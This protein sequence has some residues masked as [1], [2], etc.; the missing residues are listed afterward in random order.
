MASLSCTFNLVCVRGA[1]KFNASGQHVLG[2]EVVASLVVIA[3]FC[4]HTKLTRTD[5]AG[6]IMGE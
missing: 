5:V 3:G 2:T 1:K 4:E 6:G